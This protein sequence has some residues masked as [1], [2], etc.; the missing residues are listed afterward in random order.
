MTSILQLLENQLAFSEGCNI[1]WQYDDK[2][3]FQKYVQYN[4]NASMNATEPI[5]PPISITP[6]VA[7]L[8]TPLTAATPKIAE[9]PLVK[10]KTIQ[11]KTGK[12]DVIKPLDIIL[13]ET[14][15]FPQA[16]DKVKDK[17]IEVL[18]MQEY[19]KVFGAKKS[20][21]MMTGIVNNKWNK[22]TALFLSFLFDKTVVYNEENIVYNKEKNNGIIHLGL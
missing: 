12:K 6:A 22:S 14:N 8:T 20:A 1:E 9:K 4:T 3:I 16:V 5:P 2:S 19:I 15:T 21:E 11:K 13:Q 18:S 10:A 17:L 7:S